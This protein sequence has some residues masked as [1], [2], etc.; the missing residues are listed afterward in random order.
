MQ[1][2]VIQNRAET[3]A[4]RI[5]MRRFLLVA[6]VLV[7]PNGLLAQDAV[8]YSA[9]AE[10]RAAFKKLLDRPK[11]TLDVEIGARAIV[12]SSLVHQLLAFTSEKKA[13]GSVER[14]PT[15]IISPRERKG[16]LP[17]VIVL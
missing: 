1:Y 7:L 12:D 4:G 17:A 5:T 8:K 2:K 14:V 6:V 16:R 15:L 13:D 9:P 10:V 3:V 11:V